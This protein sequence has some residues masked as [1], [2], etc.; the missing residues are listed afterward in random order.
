MR[1]F[2]FYTGF[3]VASTFVL[4]AQHVSDDSVSYTPIPL[5]EQKNSLRKTKNQDSVIGNERPVYFFSLN[6]GSLFGCGD[7][8]EA[9]GVSSTFSAVN[10]VAIKKLRAG[11]G[12]G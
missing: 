9:A 4:Q 10:G 1:Y 11:V 12:L 2:I 7:C 6:V 3:L 5:S 8:V